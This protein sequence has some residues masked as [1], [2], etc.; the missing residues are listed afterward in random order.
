MFKSV[1]CIYVISSEKDYFHPWSPGQKSRSTGSG[2]AVSIPSGT[3]KGQYIMTNFHV[4]RGAVMV[5]IKKYSSDKKFLCE[6]IDIAEEFDLALLKVK[7][8][9]EKDFW[10]DVDSI[11]WGNAP[12]R[13]V[14]VTVVGFPHEGTNASITRG[15]VSRITSHPY[16]GYP[17]IAIQ[18]DAAVNPGNSGGPVLYK[19]QIVGVAFSHTARTMNMCYMIPEFL[20]KHFMKGFSKFGKFPGIC[21]LGIFTAS[22]ENDTLRQYLLGNTK[23]SGILVTE[24]FPV[25]SSSGVLLENDVI[26]K[27][28][29]IN[30]HNDQHI[31][32]VKYEPSNDTNVKDTSLERAPYWHTVRLLFPGDKIDVQV[33]RNRISKNMRITLNEISDLAPKMER[34]ISN[35]Y[36]IF[37]GI[38]FLPL[39]HWHVFPKDSNDNG[40]SNINHTRLINTINDKIKEY[41][42]QQI[43]FISDLLPCQSLNGYDNDCKFLQLTKVNDIPIKNIRHLQKICFQPT[44]STIVDKIGKEDEFIKFE[45]ID[46]TI[47]ILNWQTAIEES[48]VI[49]KQTFNIEPWK[50][51]ENTT[52]KT[53]KTEK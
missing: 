15:I 4:V 14:E 17:N 32:M 10:S 49:A 46:K 52:K 30:V 39:C 21:N 47:I 38:V 34:N 28:N 6:V 42:D 29:G 11:T 8:S 48:T 25:G 36:L 20:A 43:I 12:K 22:L 16:N 23:Q 5:Q 33:I 2:F 3:L 31:F 35:E 9:D 51:Q 41:S 50:I 40:I 7:E 13:G 27:I 19:D 44:K 37:S 18:I 24:V 26:N 45:F 1:V 53:E